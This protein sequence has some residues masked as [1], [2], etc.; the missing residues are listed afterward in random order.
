MDNPLKIL[1]YGYGNPGRRDDGLGPT[2]IHLV[3]K[4][5]KEQKIRNVFTDANY[6]LNIEDACS[7]RDYDIVIF[8]DASIEELP[9][10]ELTR[11]KP[12][13]KVSYTMHAMHPSFVLDL[14]GKIYGQAPEV[15]LMKIKGYEFNLMEGLSDSAASNL[16]TA[17]SAIKKIISNP[18][19]YLESAISD[20]PG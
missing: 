3:T 9:G 20:V 4:W 14:C 7:I 16:I 18:E 2:C 5:L 10:Y 19:E 13:G 8:V 17:F 15:L 1:I 12:S 11:V 6:Q